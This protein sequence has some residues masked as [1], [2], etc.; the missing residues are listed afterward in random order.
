MRSIK[1]RPVSYELSDKKLCK[2]VAATAHVAPYERGSGFKR[3]HRFR[4]AQRVINTWLSGRDVM[5]EFGR[6]TVYGLA[7]GKPTVAT[8][9]SR[10]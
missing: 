3:S 8:I 2:M 4:L 6:E 9:K 5:A 10:R 1:R 7:H